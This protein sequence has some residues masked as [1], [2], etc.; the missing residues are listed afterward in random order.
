MHDNSKSFTFF[1]SVPTKS[2]ANVTDAGS[3]SK[4]LPEVRKSYVTHLLPTLELNGDRNKLKS[5]QSYQNLS[6]VAREGRDKGKMY[7]PLS[8]SLGKTSARV[9]WRNQT[10]RST[11]S[12]KTFNDVT[13]K[14]ENIIGNLC[15]TGLLELLGSG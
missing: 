7:N 2:N 8:S 12:N 3:F 13:K 15:H 14:Y 11:Q 6:T 9:R 4:P 5:Y 1:D 10:A